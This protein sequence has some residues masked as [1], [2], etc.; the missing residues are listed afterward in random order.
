MSSR[1][2]PREVR[3]LQQQV[4]AL[5]GTQ[6]GREANFQRKAEGAAYKIA[7]LGP[8]QAGK[9]K[10]AAQVSRRD[11]EHREAQVDEEDEQRSYVLFRM[12]CTLLTSIISLHAFQIAGIDFPNKYEPTAGVRILELTE[13]I[14]TEHG[15]LS[16]AVELWDCSGDQKYEGCWS[17]LCDKLDGALV[18]FDPTN[19][20]QANDVRIWCEWFCKR[21]KL[22]D[23]QVAIF[24]HGELSGNHKPLSVRAGDRTVLVPIVNVSTVNLPQPEEDGTPVPGPAKVEFRNFMA[25]VHSFSTNGGAAGLPQ[26]G[27]DGGEEGGNY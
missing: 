21:A 6:Q 10:I 7:L 5:R 9:T 1:D 20:A 18:C 16:Q 24:A 25:L 27:Q 23:G 15:E 12:L 22:H 4:Q 13:L 3:L 19:K 11:E 14:Q 17:A 26:G 2:D 8:L